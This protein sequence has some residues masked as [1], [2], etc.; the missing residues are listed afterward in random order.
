MK[1]FKKLHEESYETVCR[2]SKQ[3][4]VYIENI[5]MCIVVS[6]FYIEDRILTKLGPNA[7]SLKFYQYLR[8][9]LKDEFSVNDNVVPVE[10]LYQLKNLENKISDSVKS[11]INKEEKKEIKET[12]T[13]PQNILSMPEPVYRK[14]THSFDMPTPIFENPIFSLKFILGY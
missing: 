5:L 1:K 3:P 8:L 4:F 12:F 10:D 13:Y 9:V 6:F 7:E 2:I 14:P 11:M